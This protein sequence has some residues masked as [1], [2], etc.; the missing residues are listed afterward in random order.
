[1]SAV[2]LGAICAALIAATVSMVGLILSKEQKTSE[3]RQEWINK[4]REEIA[5]YVSNV[6]AISDQIKIN[7]EDNN[8]KLK[9][10][11]PF[12][13]SINQA[14]NAIRLRLN[15]EEEQSQIIIGI[16]E[17]LERASQSDYQFASREIQ[18]IEER[19]IKALQK[20]LKSEWVR[21]R[22][23]EQTFVLAKRSALG[24]S[25]ILVCLFAFAVF[26]TSGAPGSSASEKTVVIEVGA[27]SDLPQLP[28]PDVKITPTAVPTATNLTPAKDR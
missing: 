11:S 12:Y 6:S 3:F 26:Q 4:L 17:E 28:P 13:S 10:L 18:E 24:I 7:F 19:L 8:E 21:V 5:L 1:M 16:M 14:S 23:G 9:Y 20:L 15:P 27:Q 25:F 2:T 22:E